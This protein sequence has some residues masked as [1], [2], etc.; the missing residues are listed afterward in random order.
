MPPEGTSLARRDG[1]KAFPAEQESALHI[2]VEQAG[3]CNACM[4]VRV[5]QGPVLG[6]T[7]APRARNLDAPKGWWYRSCVS[8]IRILDDALADQIAAGEV[9]ERPA[10]VV[11]ELLENA[12][13]AGAK[14][15]RVEIEGGGT[16]GMV[17]TDDGEGM[18]PED[19]KLAVLRHATSKIARLEDLNAIRTLGFRGEALPSI[20]SV[21]RFELLTRTRDAVAGTRVAI[22]GG[23]APD[24]R[25]IGCAPGT[26]VRVMDLF[27]NVPAR[28]KFSKSIGTESAHVAEVCRRAALAHPELRLTLVRDGRRSFEVLPTPDLAKRAA[29]VFSAEKLSAIEG[30]RAG[31]RVV[32]LLGAPEKARAGAQGLCLYVNQR[33]V[34]DRALAR[35]VSFA[36]GS[37]LPPGRYPSGVVYIAIDPSEVDVNVHPQKAEVRFARGREVLDAITRVLA[38]GLGTSAW[39]GPAARGPSFWQQRIEATGGS[40]PPAPSEPEPDPWGLAAPEASGVAEGP[41]M[42]IAPAAAPPIPYPAPAA[43]DE[44]PREELLGEVGFFA[45]LRVLGQ[46]RRMLIVCEG[47]DGL[48]V[49]DQHAADER[50]RFDQLRRSYAARTVATQRLLMPERVELSEEDVALCEEHREALLAVGLDVVPLGDRTVAVH[51]VP[52][53]VRRAPPERL[54][55]DIL[56]ELERAGERAF[57]DAVDMALA[58]MACHGAIRAGDPLSLDECR[59]LL[60]AMDAVSDFS[61][62]CPHGRP[63]VYSVPFDELERRLGR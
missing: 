1:R 7:D 46:A 50:V 33:P 62:H 43:G 30:E 51:G 8:R 48:H 37:V 56:V 34:R 20:A 23:T 25:E 2:P 35:A 19:A 13:D 41:A 17:V 38:N 47:K 45:S 3:A 49:I 6:A 5:E 60:R 53:V 12:I 24:V 10:S 59:A 44:L 15:V 29:M 28:K 42:P 14:V 61:G 26:T 31:V 22:E 58:T 40:P 21:S 54:V 55:K 9:V 52:T 39:S 32:A 4:H 18:T 16:R 36:Y 11:K 63:V 27:F 57:G